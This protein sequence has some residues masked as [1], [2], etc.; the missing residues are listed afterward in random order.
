MIWKERRDG[1][2]IALILALFIHVINKFLYWARTN[3]F[4]MNSRVASAY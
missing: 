4:N 1:P 3:Y 2:L